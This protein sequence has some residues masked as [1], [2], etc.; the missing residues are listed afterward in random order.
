MINHI[1]NEKTNI[2][3]FIAHKV[4][5]ICNSSKMEEWFYV[6]T[7]Q[8]VADDFPHYK[9]FD[10]LINRSRWCIGPDFLHKEVAWQSLSI[11]SIANNKQN[12]KV[13]PVDLT[14]EHLENKETKLTN[15]TS[16]KQSNLAS[17]INW[18]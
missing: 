9:G 2:E 16:K 11:N 3:V 8:N 1:N 13:Q 14:N 7:N 12:N 10:N 6:P 17:K 15:S 5:E 4:N 18:G